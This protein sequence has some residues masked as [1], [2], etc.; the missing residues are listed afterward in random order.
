MFRTNAPSPFA[1]PPQPAIPANAHPLATSATPGAETAAA[2]AEPEPLLPAHSINFEGVPV[3]KVLE[4]YAMY[5][6][7]TLL[8]SPAIPAATMVT[9]VQETPLTRT[10]II[11]ALDA[12]L[13][14]NNIA[15][16]PIGE[17]F[18]K[19]VPLAEAGAQ[20]DKIDE[21]NASYLAEFGPYHTR[22]VQ[23]KYIK[24]SDVVPIL[25]QFTKTPSAITPVENAGML[26]L[27]DSAENMRIMLQVIAL[28]DTSVPTEIE[29]AVIPIKYT[30]ATDIA[31]ALNSFERQRRHGVL[32]PRHQ[33]QSGPGLPHRDYRFQL[34]R[35]RFRRNNVSGKHVTRRIGWRWRG[36]DPWLFGWICQFKLH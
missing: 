10:E 27:R 3:D 28:L 23:L 6:G 36:L 34:W 4:V 18:I 2:K 24:P 26:V 5:V 16:I 33:P 31:N 13:A 17:K 30:L 14:M 35:I 32:F 22:I 11:H 12:E 21:L 7:R 15:M 29:S 20:G 25:Q 19:V 9:L 1:H 8:R